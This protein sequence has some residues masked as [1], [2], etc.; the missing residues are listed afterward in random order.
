MRVQSVRAVSIEELIRS[1]CLVSGDLDMP[2]KLA[3]FFQTMNRR[4]YRPNVRLGAVGSI[5]SLG[6]NTITG[7][8]LSWGA[9]RSAGVPAPIPSNGPT[10]GVTTQRQ[11]VQ[12][13]FNSSGVGAIN[14]IAQNTTTI[15]AGAT[16]NIAMDVITN[17][18]GEA[19]ATFSAI[20]ELWIE[21]LTNAQGAAQAAGQESSQVTMGNHATNAWAAILGATGTYK[22]A[23]AGLWHHQD[24]S[25]A[26]LTVTAG[27][28][29]KTVN[30]DGS[31]AASLRMTVFGFK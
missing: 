25:S 21:L 5:D 17:V 15:G 30:N 10:A 7:I 3:R 12:Y 13:T 4:L 8:A 20:K 18:L 11:N 23:S 16:S 24:Q 6:G 22:L 14:Q 1:G 19:T 26:G 31:K 9:I 27:D 29:L 28:F 2:S